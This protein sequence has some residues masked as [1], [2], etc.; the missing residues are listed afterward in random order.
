MQT[1]F[2]Y[3]EVDLGL[4]LRL[5]ILIFGKLQNKHPGFIGQK[6]INR[7]A[8][9]LQIRIEQI[10]ALVVRFVKGVLRDLLISKTVKRI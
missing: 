2:F 10:G 3:R 6:L 5:Q 9:L 7:T 4:I 8:L 1:V